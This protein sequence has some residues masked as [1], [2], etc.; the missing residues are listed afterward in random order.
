M[1]QACDVGPMFKLTKAV[2]KSMPSESKTIS[3]IFFR[4]S[5]A[6]EELQNTSSLSSSSSSGRV[7]NL[8]SHKKKAIIAGI[9]KLPIAM[10]V[11]F[12][13]GHIQSAFKANGQIDKEGIIPNIHALAGTYRGSITKDH[14]LNDTDTIL[15]T[16]YKD[17]YLNG[18]IEESKFDKEGVV[19]DFDDEGNLISQDFGISKENCQ[20]A[21]VLSA[22]TQREERIAL[23]ADIKKNTQRKTSIII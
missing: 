9:S 11:A 20:R 5:S 3:P 7:V 23:M 17:M 19:S 15:K 10:A 18:R 22:T 4:I 1:E 16:F 8:S 6:L 2:I 12:K 21:K 13:E 14:Y